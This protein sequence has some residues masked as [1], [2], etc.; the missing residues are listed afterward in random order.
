MDLAAHVDKGG[1]LGLKHPTLSPEE[2]LAA[3]C[4]I[5]KR[6]TSNALRIYT[7]LRMVVRD[8]GDY[9][10]ANWCHYQRESDTSTER[11]RRYRERHKAVTVTD[12]EQSRTDTYRTAKSKNKTNARACAREGGGSMKEGEDPS[13]AIAY[14]EDKLHKELDADGAASVGRW[15]RAYGSS[16]TCSSIGASFEVAVRDRMAYIGATLR[17]R[18]KEER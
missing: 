13:A 4:H 10:I 2:K 14:F 3:E 17:D 8:H 6:S 7:D 18:A 1:R 11:T 16:A 9:R 15:V 12:P 5:P